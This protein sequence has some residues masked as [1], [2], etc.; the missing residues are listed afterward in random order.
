MAY[1]NGQVPL[2]AL[3]TVA[4]GVQ[5]LSAQAN[6]YRSL[7]IMGKIDSIKIG[8]APGVGSG[9]RSIAIQKLFYAAAQGDKKAAAQVGLN[10]QSTVSVA[11][12]GYSSHG[13]GTRIDLVFAGSATPNARHIELAGEH[14]WSQEFGERDPNH[15]RHDG[16]TS[17]SGPSDSDRNRVLAHFL[18]EQGLGKRTATEEDGK[19]STDPTVEQIYTW[20]LQTWLHR[21]TNRYPSQFRVD[22]KWGPQTARGERWLWTQIWSGAIAL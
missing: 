13:F 3:A 7:V 16:T 9:Y 12:P 17:I 6:A 19:H 4:T 1:R 5:L 20:L 14:G 8:P 10:P 11:A 22:G 15:F 2:T 18:N 21:N